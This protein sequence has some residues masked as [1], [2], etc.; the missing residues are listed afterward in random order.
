MLWRVNGGGGRGSV[1]DLSQKMMNGVRCIAKV[2]Y[3]MVIYTGLF[4]Q[5]SEDISPFDT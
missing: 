1:V 4:D 5:C 3:N 2:V